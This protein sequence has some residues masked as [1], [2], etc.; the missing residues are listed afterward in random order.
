[1]S[2]APELDEDV[3]VTAS[4][5]VSGAPEVPYNKKDIQSYKYLKFEH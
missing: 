3:Q 1:M 4:T 2:K 5:D